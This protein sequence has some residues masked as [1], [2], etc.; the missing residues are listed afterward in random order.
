MK[1]LLLSLVSAFAASV[2]LADVEPEPTGMIQMHYID[3][4]VV[5]LFSS[6]LAAL[7]F[8]RFVLGRKA[9]WIGFELFRA[10]P[11]EAA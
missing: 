4:M 3:F 9:K 7:G 1:K 10:K 2:A 11:Q 8:N 5:T 6:V